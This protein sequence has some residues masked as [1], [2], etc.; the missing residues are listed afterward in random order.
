MIRNLEATV[1]NVE[2]LKQLF[3]MVGDKVYGHFI[4]ENKQIVYNLSEN[5]Y[6]GSIRFHEPKSVD[7][8][9]DQAFRWANAHRD[10]NCDIFPIPDY[11]DIEDSDFE[12][13]VIFYYDGE[14]QDVIVEG[15]WD[16]I[17]N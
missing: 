9:A 8:I 1:T 14:T 15:S 5:V 7:D 4:I 13:V 17:D 16:Y 10:E 3:R 2:D 12:E 6:E 11:V